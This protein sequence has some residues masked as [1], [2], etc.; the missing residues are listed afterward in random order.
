[1]NKD[2]NKVKKPV[3]PDAI[4]KWENEPTVAELKVDYTG[5]STEQNA[6][7]IKIDET[8]DYLYVRG[9]ARQVYNGNRSQVQPALIRKQAEWR[10]SALTQPFLSTYDLF[11][12]D[13]VTPEDVASAKQ[14]EML[15]NYQFNCK[16]DKQKFIDEYVRAGVNTGTIIVQL[17]WESITKTVKQS[18]ATYTFGAPRSPEEIEMILQAMGMKKSNYPAFSVLPDELRASVKATEDNGMIPT[19]A[20]RNGSAMVEKEIKVKN[21]PTANLINYRN[22]YADPTCDGDLTKAQFVVV[23]FETSMSELE[24]MPDR[25]KNL[26]KITVSGGD[27]LT[28]SDFSKKSGDQSIGFNFSDDA[29]RKLVAHE[30]WGFWDIADDGILVPI[31]ATWIDGVMVRME[32]NPYPDQELPFVTVPYLPIEGSIYGESDGALI[33]DNQTISGA[34]MRSM[35]DTL[36]KSAAGQRGSAEGFLDYNN[37]RKFENNEDY[38]FNP[39]IHPDAGIKEHV[40]PEL[41]ASG[42]NLLSLMNSDAES[43]TGVKAYA[44]QSGISGDSLG[45]TATGARGALDAASKR[46]S[47]ILNRLADG[48]TKIGRKML[49]MNSEFLSDEEVI[50]ITAQEFVP[51]RRDDL[52]GNFDL[53]I[54][55]STAEADNAQAQ[56]LSF[57][58]QTIGPVV[59]STITMK[60]MAQIA[61]L[62]NMPALAQELRSYQPQPD[63][64]AQEKARMEMELLQMQIEEAKSKIYENYSSAKLDEGRAAAAI[65]DAELK[66]ATKAKTYLDYAEQ[67]SGITQARSV[68]KI[69]SQAEAQ[70]QTKV[71]EAA[72][73]RQENIDNQTK[74]LN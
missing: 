41:P 38:T 52:A 31:V 28:A 36:G 23:T 22:F 35:I 17:G 1:M 33:R 59:D 26:D 29:R 53:K 32:E 37:R 73:K 58:L 50:R 40:F 69:Q 27:A 8:L 70:A 65:A 74:G 25:Y 49:A 45:P 10:Y 47:G 18:E 34:L 7:V 72:L 42:F 55:V 67:E 61:D 60:L 71:I 30:Y 57:M 21:N 62:R 3:N 64:M 66:A 13:P 15:L 43:M 46:E 48:L 63:P 44:G 12:V 54:S 14:N 9:S 11:N 6:Q 2:E 4:A 56:E 5:A 19:K 51:I 68:E 39:Q 16:M 24:A 20:T